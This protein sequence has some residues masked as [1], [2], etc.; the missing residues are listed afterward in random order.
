MIKLGTRVRDSITGFSG[1]AMART[2]Y[3]NG[4]ARVGVQAAQLHDGKPVDP[5]WFD[6]QQLTEDSP[7]TAGGPGSVAPSR[8]APNY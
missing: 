6:E 2:E 5:Q 4:C 1:V 7:A 8:D 3:L